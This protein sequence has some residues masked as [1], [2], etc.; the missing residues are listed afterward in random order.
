VNDIS[1]LQSQ[2]SRLRTR[3]DVTIYPAQPINDDSLPPRGLRSAQYDW[4]I[5]G[6]KFSYERKIIGGEA[7]ATTADSD[8]YADWNG[9]EWK[10]WNPVERTLTIAQQPSLHVELDCAWLF[11]CAEGP[12][13]GQRESVVDLLSGHADEV[14][15]QNSE[16]HFKYYLANR[17]RFIEVV[18]DDLHLHRLR[19]MAIEGRDA[20]TDAPRYRIEFRITGWGKYNGITLPSSA[21]R[22]SWSYASNVGRSINESTKQRIIFNRLEVS[23]AAAESLAKPGG[24]FTVIDKRLDLI[25]TVGERR[26]KLGGYMADTDSI[27]SIIAPEELGALPLRFVPRQSPKHT[28]SGSAAEAVSPPRPYLLLLGSLC[29]VGVAASTKFRPLQRCCLVVVG[30]TLFGVSALTWSSKA[31]PPDNVDVNEK[32]HDFGEIEYTGEVFSK[33]YT[34]TLKNKAG[35]DRTIAAIKTT[36]GCTSATASS[37]TIKD[38]EE[39]QGDATIRFSEPGYHSQR[40]WVVYENGDTDELQL[41]G[42]VRGNTFKSMVQKSVIVMPNMPTTLMLYVSEAPDYTDKSE[43]RIH[44]PNGVMAEAVGWQV[45]DVGNKMTGR[46]KRSIYSGKLRADND[47]VQRAVANVE[48]ERGRFELVDLTGWAWQH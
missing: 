16:L 44:V 30:L 1:A 3:Y 40:I 19:M 38:G 43:P 8:V 13:L 9:S 46:L 18:L 7:G 10:V 26:L 5:E 4:R 21:E 27:E 23:D 14:I 31:G 2:T 25:Y 34:F 6:P 47:L 12:V 22:T 42:T 48:F 41:A 33:Q 29:V 15:H 39:F 17:R 32:S 36:C 20:A 45:I 35:R 28:T 11:N 24:A 37:K